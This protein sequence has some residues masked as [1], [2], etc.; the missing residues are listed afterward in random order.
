MMIAGLIFTISAF[1][2]L[3]AM[4]KQLFETNAFFRHLE[5]AHPETFIRLGSPKW[6]IQFGDTTF[7]D[8]MKYIRSG[9]FEVLDD[10]ILSQHYRSMRNAERLAYAVA[11]VAITVTIVQA[12]QDSI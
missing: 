2:F 3:V 5:Q 7:R 10:A 6:H 11:A 1:I 12:V 4:L 9:E 8:A